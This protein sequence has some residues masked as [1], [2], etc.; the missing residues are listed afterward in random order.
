M[1]Q[2][3]F[4]YFAPDRLVGV[5]RIE[6]PEQPA[7]SARLVDVI[8][9][10][11]RF[12]AF[13]RDGKRWEP[14][15]PGWNPD[16][17]YKYINFYA[18]SHSKIRNSFDNSFPESLSY[19]DV[20]E[21]QEILN[22]E[23]SYDNTQTPQCFRD[24]SELINWIQDFVDP[25]PEIITYGSSRISCGDMAWM[26]PDVEELQSLQEATELYVL[27]QRS[28][29]SSQILSE[30][31]YPIQMY[32]PLHDAVVDAFNEAG[33]RAN[34]VDCL[35]DFDERMEGTGVDNFISGG[36]ASMHQLNA[37][38]LESLAL[39]IDYQAPMTQRDSD[40]ARLTREKYTKPKNRLEAWFLHGEEKKLT[41]L[42]ANTKYGFFTRVEKGQ[43]RPLIRSREDEDVFDLAGVTIVHLRPEREDEIIKEFDKGVLPGMHLTDW[44][45]VKYKLDYRDDVPSGNDYYDQVDHNDRSGVK[46][47]S[48]KR[49]GANVI[50]EMIY[51]L[52]KNIRVLREANE[53]VGLLP[54]NLTILE[55]FMKG[56]I[57][58]S[59]VHIHNLLNE[60]FLEEIDTKCANMTAGEFVAHSTKNRFEEL[61][62]RREAEYLPLGSLM[63]VVAYEPATT[64]WLEYRSQ[65]Y[66]SFA[67]IDGGWKSGNSQDSALYEELFLYEVKEECVDDFIAAYDAVAEDDGWSSFEELAPMLCFFRMNQNRAG[68]LFNP[69]DWDAE[70]FMRDQM[71]P[72]AAAVVE[73]L[74][75]SVMTFINDYSEVHEDDDD[76][77]WM[78]VD[79][80]LSQIWADH[81]IEFMNR[82]ST[83]NR[84]L[85]GRFL[86][87][88]PRILQDPRNV[89]R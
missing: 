52:R 21:H 8:H 72:S 59:Y 74:Y 83:L 27:E 15:W 53:E 81:M 2:E 62:E 51:E 88:A 26:H 22:W 78:Q 50:R 82:E 42:V 63:L 38:L 71:P 31:L 61:I 84:S 7:T 89:I 80:W 87:A 18:K 6:D 9:L 3:E 66:G 32:P 5:L 44:K 28:K 46:F 23:G 1:T 67:R 41:H 30:Q 20:K 19:E 10:T 33:T 34:S 4:A 48:L 54:A 55:A 75:N 70:P 40:L 35:D 56:Q 86:D 58:L 37:Y 73:Y 47:S 14:M 43:W 29:P 68:D 85:L 24:I 79:E 76:D 12:G 64:M 77:S 25:K 60:C 49:I 65:S 39:G 36:R 69:R 13:I 17:D 45:L 57:E 16:P 11:S